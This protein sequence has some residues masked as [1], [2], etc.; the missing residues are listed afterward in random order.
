M[1]QANGR[2]AGGGG[3]DHEQGEQAQASAVQEA[4]RGHQAAGSRR[5]A[6]NEHVK[7][8]KV[9]CKDQERVPP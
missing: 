9:S 8:K 5:W 4:A 1:G 2:E 3:W 6:E 7:L